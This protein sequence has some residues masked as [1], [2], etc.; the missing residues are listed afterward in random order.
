LPVTGKYGGIPDVATR[1]I[2]TTYTV[3][4]ETVR[5]LEALARKWKVSKSEALCRA[6]HAATR[7]ENCAD[8]LGALDDLQASL[9]MTLNEATEW[10]DVVRAERRAI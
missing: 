6:V 3:D 5:C 8:A 7:E 9:G 2:R 4:V 10:A 1:R